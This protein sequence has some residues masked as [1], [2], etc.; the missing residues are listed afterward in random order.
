[1]NHVQNFKNKLAGQ[2]LKEFYTDASS[3]TPVSSNISSERTYC[4]C[5]YFL[6]KKELAVWDLFASQCIIMILQELKHWET[7]FL[8][9]YD[10]FHKIY[11]VYK[12]P[13]KKFSVSHSVA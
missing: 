1:M 9:S 8:L 4:E 3:H 12:F 7:V 2:R 10:T 6:I 11:S 13:N 5:Y